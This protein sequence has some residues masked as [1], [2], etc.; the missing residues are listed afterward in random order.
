MKEKEELIKMEGEQGKDVVPARC[1]KP[2]GL[3]A[4][5]SILLPHAALCQR[6]WS[7]LLG[8]QQ[9]T[10]ERGGGTVIDKSSDGHRPRHVLL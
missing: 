2:K 1:T 4:D 8:S 5:G 10:Q 7:S 3:C 6:N 9:N